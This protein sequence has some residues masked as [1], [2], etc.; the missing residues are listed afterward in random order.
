[1]IP[2]FQRNEFITYWKTCGPGVLSGG[3]TAAAPAPHPDRA[4]AG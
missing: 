1:M 4:A 3:D 2:I